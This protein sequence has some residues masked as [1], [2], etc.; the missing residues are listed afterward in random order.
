MLSFLQKTFEYTEGA[1]EEYWGEIENVTVL[2]LEPLSHII[3]CHV[4]V[5]DCLENLRIKRLFFLFVISVVLFR[6]RNITSLLVN[7]FVV[8]KDKVLLTNLT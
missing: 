6:D 5:A 7:L 2:L 1:H 8:F 4:H 3:S